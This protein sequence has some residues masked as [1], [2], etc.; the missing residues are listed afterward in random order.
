MRERHLVKGASWR[1]GVW[2]SENRVFFSTC[3]LARREVNLK[4]PKSA[5]MAGREVLV[6]TPGEQKHFAELNFAA[7]LTYSPRLRRVRDRRQTSLP[8]PNGR[9]TPN[10]S[11]S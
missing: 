6:S 1:A 3:C 2:V 5:A 10:N 7:G 9:T 8:F 11:Y 4:S